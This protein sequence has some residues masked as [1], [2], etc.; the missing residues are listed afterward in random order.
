MLMVRTGG[1]AMHVGARGCNG[2][3]ALPI[4]RSR[5]QPEDRPSAAV[6]PITT[7][8]VELKKIAHR[9]CSAARTRLF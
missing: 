6:E 9:P 8:Q 5:Q 7:K 2:E 1:Q 3:D 4:C